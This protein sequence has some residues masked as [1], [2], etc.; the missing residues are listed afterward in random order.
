MAC[1]NLVSRLCF[2]L[3]RQGF[4]PKI[5]G[6]VGSYKTP[7]VAIAMITCVTVAICIGT[8]SMGGK[9]E[10]IFSFAVDAG[11]VMVQTSYFLV[12]IGGCVEF[13]SIEAAV[14]ATVPLGAVLGSL[15]GAT[16]SLGY[17]FALVFLVF[18]GLGVACCAWC[19]P[20]RIARAV[21]DM[22]G[23]TEIS[24]SNEDSN[25]V[26]AEPLLKA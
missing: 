23:N 14:A 10:T 21:E 2:A 4:L 17:K 20:D 3:S 24:S 9:L 19:F 12:M 13:R 1:V 18:L 8:V 5:L 25:K 15:M 22:H 7:Y 26:E 6:N 11:G 16:L